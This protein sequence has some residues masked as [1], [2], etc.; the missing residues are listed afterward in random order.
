MIVL[1]GG[2]LFLEEDFKQLQ[3]AMQEFG[4]EYF[5]IIQYSQEF[6]D[7]EPMFRMKFPEHNLGRTNKRKLYISRSFGNELQRIFCVWYEWE[8][9]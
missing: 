2:C 1:R 3:K 6:T 5:V 4:E 8:L 9:W 7:K